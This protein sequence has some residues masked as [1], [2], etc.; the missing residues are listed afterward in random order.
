M[1]NYAVSINL[2][3]ISE[4]PH[5]NIGYNI[6]YIFKIHV[7]IAKYLD[8]TLPK[9]GV[10]AVRLCSILGKYTSLLLHTQWLFYLQQVY[11]D[12]T[13]LDFHHE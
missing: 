1:P 3:D 13:I 8:A 10:Y 2:N 5:L 6:W 11:I 12:R 9:F 7:M 4:F